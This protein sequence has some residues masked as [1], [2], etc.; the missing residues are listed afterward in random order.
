MD[1]PHVVD[2]AMSAVVQY[3]VTGGDTLSTRS[4]DPQILRTS[5]SSDPWIQGLVGSWMDCAIA[6]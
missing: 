1:K 6:L 2:M 3:Y 4:L 5:E